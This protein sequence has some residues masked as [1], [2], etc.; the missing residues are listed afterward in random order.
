MTWQGKILVVGGFADRLDSNRTVPYTLERSSAEVFDPRTGRWDLM[1]GMWQLDV[2][3]NQIV[4]V[5][6]KLFSSGDCLMAWK[7]HIEAYDMD[8]NIWNIVDGS[9]FGTPCP[10]VYLTV[11]PLGSLLYFLAGY[12]R[13]GG[14]DSD[15]STFVSMVHVFDTLAIG[16]AWRSLDP[17]DQVGEKELCSHGCVFQH[18]K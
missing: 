13:A 10:P 14:G 3:P 16:D 2:P 4:A 7:G 11:A 12:R 15:S 18:P 6:G 9:Q 5:E 1:A 8:Q 17:I